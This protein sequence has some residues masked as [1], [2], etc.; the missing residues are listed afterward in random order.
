[1]KLLSGDSENRYPTKSLSIHLARTLFT[2]WHVSNR[3]LQ[4][5]YYYLM[6]WNHLLVAISK[7]SRYLINLDMRYHTH[8]WGKSTLLCVSPIT[9]SY[10]KPA[11][12]TSSHQSAQCVSQSSFRHYGP[13]LRTNH[14]KRG[15]SHRK[16]KVYRPHLL[17]V[18]FSSIENQTYGTFFF[19]KLEV[20]VAGERVGSQ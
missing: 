7:L 13:I 1:M 6:L 3:N 8:D 10:Y 4:N 17:K 20:Y 16:S 15:I 19:D 9:N 2:R 5:T 11:R 18:N 14:F 12:F